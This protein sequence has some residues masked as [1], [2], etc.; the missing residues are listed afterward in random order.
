MQHCPSNI[1]QILRIITENQIPGR[2][3]QKLAAGKK[4]LIFIHCLYLGKIQKIQKE[5][6][7]LRLTR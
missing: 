7:E 6:E 3:I 5:S 4:K 1:F 2:S